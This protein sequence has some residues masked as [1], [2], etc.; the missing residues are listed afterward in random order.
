MRGSPTP[1]INAVMMMMIM[2]IIIIMDSLHD[3]TH[4]SSCMGTL[5]MGIVVP[6]ILTRGSGTQTGGDNLKPRAI[7]GQLVMIQDSGTHPG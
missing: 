3:C 5:Y 2:I 4:N 7:E 6:M 1:A